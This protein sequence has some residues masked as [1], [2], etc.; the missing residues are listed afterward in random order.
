MNAMVAGLSESR[1]AVSFIVE[2]YKHPDQLYD[3]CSRLQHP[4][5]EVLI[6][7]D[8]NTS[9]DIKAFDHVAFSFSNVRIVYSARLNVHE[10]RA[11]NRAALLAR[12]WLLAFSQDDR[13]PPPAPPT[14][15]DRVLEIY[16]IMPPAFAALGL[17]RGSYWT[18]KS[19]P[20]FPMQLSGAC[21]DAATDASGLNSWQ[22][23][24]TRHL[25]QPVAFAGFLNI[26][27]VFV[28]RK[29][30][31]AV[32][33]FNVSYS[34]RGQPGIGLDAEITAKLWLHGYQAGLLC[35]A[36][37]TFF[38]NGCGGKG[39]I[40]TA[41]ASALRQQQ[42]ERNTQ[43]FFNQFSSNARSVIISRVNA[44][45]RQL[46][47][48]P[49]RLPALRRVITKCLNCGSA[50]DMAL[51]QERFHSYDALCAKST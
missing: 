23:L 8:S 44:S 18:W 32:G 30:F 2:Y 39:T 37:E 6:H 21:G 27:P 43:T 5:L 48:D 9:N 15:V 29:A 11:Y 16:R 3:L 13:I 12:G 1:I 7:A 40:K 4:Q 19:V 24:H 20:R 17:H 50:T 36:L 41:A 51:L 45:Y 35:P 47:Q 22:P 14:W 26:G 10:V 34:P 25:L 33:G 38:R 31:L 49:D 42:E 28:R 46:H